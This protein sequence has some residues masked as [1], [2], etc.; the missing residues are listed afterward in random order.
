MSV[1]RCRSR[2]VV[3]REEVEPSAVRAV[4]DRNGWIFFAQVDRDPERGIFYEVRWNVPDG[5]TM[6]Y[7]IDEVADCVYVVARHDDCA[8]AE[9][10]VGEVARQLPS[11]TLEEM[12]HDFDVS[13]Y[14]AGWERALLRLGAGAPVQENEEVVIRVRESVQHKEAAVRRAAV[15]AMV[16]TEWPVF[17]DVLASVAETD[18]DTEVARAA[19]L[20]AEQFDLARRTEQ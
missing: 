12:L 6:H 15:W 16:Y 19:A 14:P 9:R 11:W 5:G 20:A 10:A 8:T 13:I 2:N 1:P 18:S 3:L 7:I 17:R 4:A